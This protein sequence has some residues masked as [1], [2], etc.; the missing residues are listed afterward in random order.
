[1]G[2]YKATYY[3]RYEPTPYHALEH[4]FNHYELKSSDR[5][6][7]F[8]CGKGRM[9]FYI[10][11]RFGA[12]VTGIEMNESLYQDAV[13]NQIRYERKHTNRKGEIQFQCVYA[14]EYRINPMD[15]RFYFFNPFSIQIFIKV[16]NHILQSVEET[17]R[18][19]DLIFYYIS[20]D[21]IHYLENSTSFELKEEIILPD[22]YVNNT[23][24]RFLI[25]TLT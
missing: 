18:E 25:Y 15:N 2:F 11:Y 6:V 23:N 3:H 13:K 24:E 7:D 12:T 14:E 1:M 19:V 9:L 17:Q 20:E 4:F 22:L 21:Y 16:I 10:H 5:I 8:G